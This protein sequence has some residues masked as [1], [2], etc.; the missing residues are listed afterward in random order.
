MFRIASYPWETTMH[1]TYEITKLTGSSAGYM[2]RMLASST[3]SKHA[4]LK[5]V[6]R[7]KHNGQPSEP[8]W[9]AAALQQIRRARACIH[10][11]ERFHV[12]DPSYRNCPRTAPR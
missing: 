2:S 10:E 11:R 8:I 4:V 1:A 7:S 5:H 9:P 6:A 12:I 3:S